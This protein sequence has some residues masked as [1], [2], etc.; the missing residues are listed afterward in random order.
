[1]K[2]TYRRGGDRDSLLRLPVNIKSVR[3]RSQDTETFH[4]LPTYQQIKKG[5]GRLAVTCTTSSS[6]LIDHSNSCCRLHSCG[7]V[8]YA[9]QGL[10]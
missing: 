1:M 9:V 5:P 4:R 10:V 2:N 6:R 3:V 8:Y 7:T